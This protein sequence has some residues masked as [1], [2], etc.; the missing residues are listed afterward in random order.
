MSFALEPATAH[1]DDFFARVVD[2]EWLT[3]NSGE[4]SALR[5]IDRSKPNQAWRVLH[6]VPTSSAPS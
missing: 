6:R 4:A 2:P 1:F 3:G 5:Q